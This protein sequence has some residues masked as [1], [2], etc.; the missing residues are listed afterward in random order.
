MY[1][2]APRRALHPLPP[3]KQE[4]DHEVGLTR[5]PGWQHQSAPVE[6]KSFTE[7][8]I[9]RFGVGEQMSLDDAGVMGSFYSAGPM[10]RPTTRPTRS[11][12][13]RCW[14]TSHTTGPKLF[15]N[16]L[17]RRLPEYRVFRGHCRAIDE[18]HIDPRLQ[19]EL[20]ARIAPGHPK[21]QP[22]RPA[23]QDRH[24]GQRDA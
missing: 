11:G 24:Y 3:F 21:L 7:L 9:G 18:L 14:F 23:D 5:Q 1:R 12:C 13:C 16:V 19:I 20:L 8:V 2:P 10:R 22:S 6:S 17:L 15:N 4:H